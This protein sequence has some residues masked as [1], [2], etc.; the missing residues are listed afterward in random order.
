[1]PY[2][3]TAPMVV[4]PD[5]AGKLHA[6]HDG[7]TIAW[8]PGE[9]ARHLLSLDMVKKVD[10]AAPAAPAPDGPPPPPDS[11]DGKPKRPAQ[12][13]LKA[14]WVAYVVEAGLAT[15]EEAEKLDKAAMFAL[16]DGD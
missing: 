10:Q 7:G 11:G 14:D 2:I 4:V 9:V 6:Y 16:A 1:M 15:Q 3:V 12:T 13:A 5:Q 8:L